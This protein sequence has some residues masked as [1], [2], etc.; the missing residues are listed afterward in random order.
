VTGINIEGE[1][2]T[3]GATLIDSTSSHAVAGV[4][5]PM[6][7]ALGDPG[8]TGTV[9]AAAHRRMRARR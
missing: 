8:D 7:D 4:I 6:L 2:L 5:N 1:T 9:S 3:T